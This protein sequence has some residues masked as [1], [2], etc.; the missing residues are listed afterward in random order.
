MQYLYRNEAL[1]N[2]EYLTTEINYLLEEY[3]KQTETLDFEDAWN[4]VLKSIQAID[5]YL[6]LVDQEELNTVRKIT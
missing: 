6:A 4:Y 3:E 2:L 1:T 5:N